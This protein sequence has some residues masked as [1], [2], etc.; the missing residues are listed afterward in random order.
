[1]YGVTDADRAAAAR[2]AAESALD[3]AGVGGEVQVVSAR[4]HGARVE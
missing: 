2:R 1:V 3:A 4:N